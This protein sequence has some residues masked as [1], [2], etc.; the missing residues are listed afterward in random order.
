MQVT[1]L[2]LMQIDVVEFDASHCFGVDTNRCCGV[3]CNSL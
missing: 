2:E 1:G 3:G